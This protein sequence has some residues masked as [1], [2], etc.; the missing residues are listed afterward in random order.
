M[1]K[2]DRLQNLNLEAKSDC[3]KF[4]ADG[5]VQEATRCA[6]F[7]QIRSRGILGKWAFFN[8]HFFYIQAAR[9]RARARARDFTR[10][11]AFGRELLAARAGCSL[12]SPVWPTLICPSTSC[13]EASTNGEF[14]F[15]DSPIL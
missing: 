12:R 7:G 5:H 15:H 3:Q 11:S 1:A 10:T 9:A 6:K 13:Q 4:V 8:Y 14:C 2:F